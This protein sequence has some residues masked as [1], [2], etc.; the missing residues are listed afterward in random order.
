MRKQNGLFLGLLKVFAVMATVATL[1]GCT[2]FDQDPFK[3]KEDYIKNATS[4]D[5]KPS[6]DKMLDVDYF[7][8]NN[9]ANNVTQE[10]VEI[11][12]PL[13]TKTV[14]DGYNYSFEIQN[15][16]EFPDAKIDNNSFVWTP[17]YGTLTADQNAKIF[18]IKI[19]I[20]A[21]PKSG[22]SSQTK[23]SR[24]DND[25][26][27]IVESKK[28]KPII[29]S[30]VLSAPNNVLDEGQLYYVT[31]TAK[32][33]VTSD[34]NGSKPK[35][36]IESKPNMKTVAP[37]TY[38]T[39]GR[40]SASTQ[41]WIFQLAIDLKNADITAGYDSAP[42]FLTYV[43]KNEQQST[44][45]ILNIDVRTLFGMPMSTFDNL[46]TLKVGQENRVPFTIYDSKN[47][48][49]LKLINTASL[50]LGATISCE[51]SNRTFQQC[52]LIWTPTVADI[53]SYDSVMVIETRSSSL[54]DNRTVKNNV[55]ISYKVMN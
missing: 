12:I 49:I 46:T 21:E 1:V 9:S 22:S 3:A 39:G 51:Q 33:T 44:P 42:I 14:L 17:R 35:V 54:R 55:I 5:N 29:K 34:A 28:E 26:L 13:V 50:P 36:F 15:K 19:A 40:Y 16:E 6:I 32:D 30:V 41:E 48:S 24:K 4:P 38:V 52:F 10:G 23:M 2:G 37:Y 31:L 11:R 25:L 47:E 53:G 20:K 8:L 18:N 45:Y 27:V 7:F 43:N